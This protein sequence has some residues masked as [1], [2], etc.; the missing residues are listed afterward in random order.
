M[1]YPID[2]VQL[3]W[4]LSASE[5]EKKADE[6]IEMAKQVYDE[7]GKLSDAEVTIDNVCTR[8]AKLDS[9]YDTQRSQLDFFQHVS[10]DKEIRDA[11]CAADKK[12]SD[13]D[14][15]ISMR[16]DV[17]D[18]LVAV[19]KNLKQPLT[20]EDERYLSKLIKFGKR[21]GL[22][23]AEDVQ[24]Q[25]KEIKQRM[26]AISID[27]SKNLGE[28]DTVLLF[29][30]EEMAGAADDFLESLDKSDDGKY[31]VTL[32]YPHYFPCM[33]F[34]RVPETRK[35]LE[36]AFNSRCMEPNT[37][38]MEELVELRDKRA[39]LLGFKT[40]AHFVLEMRM[41]KNPE[42]VKEFLEDLASKLTKLRDD[43]MKI[44]LEYKKEECEKYGYEFN[45]KIDGWDTRYYMTRVEEKKYAVDQ[46]IL[47]EY[48]P[49][50]KVTKGLLEIYQ[51]LLG[52]VFEEIPN[53]PIWNN[54][55]TLFATKD[56]ETGE[57]LGYFYLDLYPRTGKYGH[58][59]CFTLQKGCDLE[60]GKRQLAVAAMVANFTKPTPEKPALL[61]HDEVETFF[62]EFG[63]VMHVICARAKYA[64]FSGTS[65]ERDF[66][67]APSQMLENWCWHEDPLRLMSEHY[68]TKEPIPKEVIEKLIAS[69][70]ANAGY[71]NMRQIL[72]GTF[73]QTIHS[74]SKVDTAEIFSK[75]SKE[76][77]CVE[78]SENTNMPATFEHLSGGYDAQYYG[79]MWSEVFSSDM[80]YSRFLKEGILSEKVG[81]S[82]RD[83][84]LK[85]GGSI[86]A[87]LM[88][89]N[90]LGREP[91]TEPFL[92]MKGLK[93]E[94]ES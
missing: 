64:L 79:Y 85:P 82:Y 53:P 50:E 21:N 37:K 58:A 22:H 3:R 15:E 43:E 68:K 23:L 42:R 10:P 75:L 13:F 86:D 73:D 69:R 67:E 8:L 30:K 87:D 2:N 33:K 19:E 66:V 9:I 92:R 12:L 32:K 54:D 74:L 31:K 26:S 7:V 94:N 60:N 81:K 47:K 11:S 63:H 1:K 88:L 61:T 91:Q 29:T 35:K 44:F 39:K 49:M 59:A 6:L 34:V 45:G 55:V 89:K 25:I 41:A 57:L 18:S 40:H 4:D 84:I 36:N 27:F 72:L 77:V 51:N 65:V 62:H 78:P 20:G 46:N 14:V 80:F 70:L 48:F 24:K 71:F 38:I 90:F 56:K 5:I 76:L 93:I 52:L 16:Q 83:C 17:F 28:E